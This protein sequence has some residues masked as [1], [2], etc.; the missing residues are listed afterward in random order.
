M[1]TMTKQIGGGEPAMT[2][3]VVEDE[4]LIRRLMEMALRRQG[5][6]V[7]GASCGAE[8][9][10]LFYENAAAIDLLIT[11]LSLPKIRG[12]ELAERAR[13][14]RPDLPVIYASGSFRMEPFIS[15]EYVIGA[16]YLAKPFTIEDLMQTV[17]AMMRPVF[18]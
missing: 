12:T 1:D 4:M 7:I 13:E 3:L 6:R 5:F 18:R 11:D 10:N 16:S 15:D 8:G 2:V 17:D 9:L 14:V